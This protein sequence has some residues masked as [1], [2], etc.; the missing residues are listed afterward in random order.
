MCRNVGRGRSNAG[1]VDFPSLSP[2][3]VTSQRHTIQIE[4]APYMDEISAQVGVSPSLLKLLLTDPR[5]GLEVLLGPVTPYQYRLTG[6]GKWAGAR[7]AILTQWERVARPF[8]TR[9]VPEPAPSPSGLLSSPWLL[10]LFGGS[11]VLAVLVFHGRLRAA[12]PDAAQ[13]L[14]ELPVLLGGIL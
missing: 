3:Y 4:Y 8:R 6:P 12:L 10:T 1:R 11:V 13:L 2:R 5:L 14:E 7:Q 9:E